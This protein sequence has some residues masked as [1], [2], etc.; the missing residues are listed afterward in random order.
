MIKIN[1]I[2]NNVKWLNFIKRPNS[3]I[4]RQ[5][6]K[7]NLKNKNFKKKLFIARYYYQAPKK[8]EI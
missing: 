6:K 1:V 3:Y 7:I 4:D 8:S 2:T 5:V